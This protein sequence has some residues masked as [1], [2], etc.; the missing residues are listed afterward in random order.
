MVKS[1][2]TN[3]LILAKIGLIPSQHPWSLFYNV[4]VLSLYF[5]TN[6]K[7]LCSSWFSSSVKF[8]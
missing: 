3:A 2:S 7:A 1:F 5:F 6:F 4:I 8:W